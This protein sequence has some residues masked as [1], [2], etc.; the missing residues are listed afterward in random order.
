MASVT[1]DLTKDPKGLEDYASRDCNIGKASVTLP[2]GRTL[3][4]DEAMIQLELSKDAMKGLAVSLLRWAHELEGDKFGAWELNPIQPDLVSSYLGV[5]WHPRSCRIVVSR[6]EFG[7]AED[8]LI[9]S[10]TT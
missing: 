1:I 8:L 2:G 10:R 9:S 4:G 3:E 5:Y 7:T 6:T